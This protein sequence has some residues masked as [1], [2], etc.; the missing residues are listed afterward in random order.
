MTLANPSRQTITQQILS[1]DH[2]A[3][4]SGEPEQARI[5]AG[6]TREVEPNLRMDAKQVVIAV[7]SGNYTEFRKAMYPIEENLRDRVGR[8][9]QRY[10]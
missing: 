6:T 8:W 2:K 4:I 5:A 9:V 3:I 10:P 7:E 1:K